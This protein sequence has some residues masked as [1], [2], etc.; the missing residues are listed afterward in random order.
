MKIRQITRRRLVTGCGRINNW[1]KLKNVPVCDFV[2]LFSCYKLC[3][4]LTCIFSPLLPYH[5]HISIC[6]FLSRN[7]IHNVVCRCDTCLI[8]IFVTWISFYINTA[9]PSNAAGQSVYKK[10]NYWSKKQA[11]TIEQV[12]VWTW[13]RLFVVVFSRF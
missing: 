13:L 8:I 5:L 6:F 12:N 4:N 2:F 10:C 11:Q 7:S 1:Q 3:C 9:I